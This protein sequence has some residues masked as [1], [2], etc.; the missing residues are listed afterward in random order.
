MSSSKDGIASLVGAWVPAVAGTLLLGW[1]LWLGLVVA[2]PERELGMSQKIFYL[3]APIG[4]WTILLVCLAAGAGV[5]YLWK[6]RPGADVLGESA[7]ELSVLMSAVVLMTGSLWA[8][9]AW[10]AWFPWEDPRVATFLVLLLIGVAY[11]VL[12]SSIDEPDRRARYAAVL[13]IVGAADGILAYY[14]IRIW[15]TTHPQVITSKGVALAPDMKKAFLVCIAGTFFLFWALLAA[16][17][18]LGHLRQR[19]ERLEHEILDRRESPA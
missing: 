1:G 4:I 3:H 5:A 18:R 8:R 16:R 2:A 17:Y 15:N 11:L 9:P 7:M 19:V 13:A 6:R 12:R 10:G 14:A